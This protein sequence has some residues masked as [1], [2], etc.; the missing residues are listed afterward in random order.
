MTTPADGPTD[1]STL[2]TRVA[3]LAADHRQQAT[4]LRN[5]KGV[6]RD[7]AQDEYEF[8]QAARTHDTFADE[9]DALLNRNH[10]PPPPPDQNGL[11]HPGRTT[12][13][14]RQHHPRH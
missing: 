4:T 12:P 14:A 5:R 1:E 9:L 10:P 2:R 3:A 8:Q 7:A 11:R 13:H 6:G